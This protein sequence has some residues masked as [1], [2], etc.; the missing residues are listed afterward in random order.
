MPN[1]K[2]R[3]QFWIQ[4]VTKSA[5]SGGAAQHIVEM[6]PVT[7]S[8]GQQGYSPEGNTDWSKYTPSG[9]IEMTVTGEAAGEAF[10]AAVGK[11]VAITFEI[12]D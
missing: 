4:K 6:A 1:P 2:I 7:R 12:L 3:A 5:I 8:V 10:N 9:R 11:D